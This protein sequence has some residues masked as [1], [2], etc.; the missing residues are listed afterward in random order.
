MIHLLDNAVDASASDEPVRIRVRAEDERVVID[1]SDRGPGMTAEFIRDELFRPLSTSKLAGSGIG[2]WQAR[3]ILR[4][5]GGDITV[6]SRPGAGT[7]MR[8]TLPALNPA[9]SQPG[10]PV[11]LRAR[12]A[13]EQSA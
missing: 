13:E 4:T 11:K 5:A 6:L 3:D 12:T 1:I 7:T 2:A 9:A 8:I 10:E